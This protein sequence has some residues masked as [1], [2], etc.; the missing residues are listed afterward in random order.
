MDKLAWNARILAAGLLVCQS[1]SSFILADNEALLVNHPTVIF[2]MTM[3]VGAGGN[4]GNQ[5]AVR[6]IRGL[7][8]GEVDP[9]RR[10]G[11]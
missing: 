3:L 10:I 4:A 8:T 6:I 7:A 9:R 2:F 1:L 5:A 11:Q